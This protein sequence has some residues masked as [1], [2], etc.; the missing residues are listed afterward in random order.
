MLSLSTLSFDPSPLSPT[1]LT[2][3]RQSLAAHLNH[4]LILILNALLF[5]PLLMKR[6]R[7]SAG[8]I[9]KIKWQTHYKASGR[10][11]GRGCRRG[12]EWTRQVA[13]SRQQVGNGIDVQQQQQ[14][15]T[16]EA[17]KKK[18]PT[19]HAAQ[20]AQWWLN[21]RLT[22]LPRPF[23]SLPLLLLPASC[24]CCSCCSDA[25]AGSAGFSC[26]VRSQWPNA[27]GDAGAASPPLGH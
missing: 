7:Q 26:I 5:P 6:A 24:C 3:N 14:Q 23:L 10:Q 16:A 2:D 8:Q 15:C 9:N 21:T 4:Y 17:Q 27:S 11:G 25:G 19:M 18:W 20:K 1:T 22:A 13:T 12:H